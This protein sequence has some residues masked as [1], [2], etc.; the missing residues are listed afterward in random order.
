M[1]EQ[2]IYCKGDNTYHYIS[3]LPR[4]LQPFANHAFSSGGVIG[5][6]FRKFTSNFY[7]A[8]RR[9]LPDGY[10]IH[11]WNRGHYIASYVIKTEDNNYIYLSIPDVRF[12]PNEWFT[13]IL[14]RTMEHPKDW[15]GGPNRYTTLF[16]LT[17]DIQKLRRFIT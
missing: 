10:C 15:T 14:I 13:H 1:R 17:N 12:S 8:V 2:P 3:E 16:T 6:D 9:R 11:G 4:N 7:N 5:D